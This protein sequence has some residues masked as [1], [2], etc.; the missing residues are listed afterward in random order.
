MCRLAHKDSRGAGGMGESFPPSC[1]SSALHAV[2]SLFLHGVVF[3]CSTDSRLP[4]ARSPAL[5]IASNRPWENREQTIGLRGSL[6]DPV[7]LEL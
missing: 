1:F 6:V 2:Y 7:T 4:P 3:G 5:S